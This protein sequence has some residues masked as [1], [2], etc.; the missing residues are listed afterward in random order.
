MTRA[1]NKA[2]RL[3]QI[4]Q[5]LLAH[6]DGLTQAELARRL[7]VDRSVIHRNLIDFQRLY[8]T[9][10]HE[11]GR[12]S[13]DRSAYLVRVAFTLHEALAVHLAARLLATRMDRKNRHAASALR[14]LG[15]ALRRAADQI[16]RHV[17]QSADMMDDEAQRED[18]V[19]LDV[20]EKLTE[21]WARQRK[22]RIWHQSEAGERVAEYLLS[23]YFIE[24]YAVGQTTH[25]F[26]PAQLATETGWTR[27]R[28]LTF[29]IERIRRAELTREPYSTPAD[30]DP[31]EFLAD[32]WGIWRTEDDPVEVALK[33]SA[34]VARRVHETRWH[35]SEQKITQ[36]DGSVIWR[37]SI[38][39]PKEMIPWIRGWGADCEVLDPP[40]L[41]QA[42][43]RE[44]ERMARMYGITLTQPTT[45]YFAHRREGE[46]REE[47]Q[48]LIEHLRNTAELAREFGREAQVGDL[49]Y[50][51]GLVH[52]LGKYSHQFQRR[53]EGGARVDHSTA[54]AKEL[55]GLL[56]GKPQEPIARL[57]AYPIL[58][59]HAGLPDF[60]NETDL[61]SGT[62]CARF[63]NTLP[64]YSAYK[65]E[66]DLSDLPFPQRFHV[67]PQP[68]RSGFSISF[69]TR[70]VFSAL[71]DAD[72]QETE[73]YVKG[74]PVRARNT[75]DMTAL[76]D[77]LDSWM[78]RFDHPTSEINRKRNETLMTCIQKGKTESP[79][80]F[81]LTVPTGGGKTLA[82]MAF[83]LHH[84]ARHGLRRIIYVIPFTSIIE[85]NAGIFK[86]IFG[87]ENVLEH[88]SNF[89]W[90]KLGQS[91][92][93][94]RT[95]SVF[96][97][98]KLAA[99]NWDIPIVVTT[100]VQ[101]FESLF[102]NRSSRC[103]KLHNIARSVVIFDEAQMLP[104]EYMQ[105]A[106]AAV[107]ELVVNYGVS[108][109]FCTA[110]QPRIERFLPPGTS[111]RELIAEPQALFDFYKRVDVKHLGELSDEELLA[112]LNCHDQVLC[113]VNTR[114]HASGLFAGLQ[115]EGN[116]HLS[117]LMCPAHRRIKL[118]EIRSRLANGQPCRVVSTTVME[119][120]IDVDFPVGYRALSGLDSI[121]QAA[122][123]VNREMKRRLGELF[124][125][126]P[127][128][129]FVKRTPSFLKQSAEVARMTLRDYPHAPIS[130]PAV[131]DFFDRLYDLHDPAISFDIKRIMKCFDSEEGKFSFETAAQDFQII[132]TP[133]VTIIIPFN[134]E[135][136][137]LIDELK[138]TPYPSSTLRKLQP[139]TVSIFE[140]EFEKL[141]SKGVVLTLED[142]YHVLNP[143]CFGEYYDCERGLLVPE[144]AGADGL[145]F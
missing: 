71:V 35:R 108:A 119:A 37:A 142:A 86:Q 137:K 82:S 91:Q 132:E 115:G 78:R 128:S 134:E 73:A 95:I 75:V 141:S 84:A 100:N 63:K 56:K 98:L 117:T 124:V 14:K 110:T 105:P 24:P 116:F 62:V 53:L 31:R 48:P 126:E 120:G 77:K 2:A 133:T 99:E 140:S 107:W 29:K 79:G 46:P 10:V 64:D 19:Y 135:A 127:Q 143:D 8:P 39:E 125:F 85:Q 94:D 87:E 43:K 65:T 12:I 102:S 121:N 49:A 123:R 129:E 106:L 9:L 61:E 28:V 138:Y 57:L 80:F 74:R 30:F 50:I 5:L 93:E 104:R 34:K 36:P 27:E 130:V 76:R 44:S 69:L 17:L 67:R 111:V 131:S 81:S 136:L 42:L 55:H 22:A 112:R 25:V 58:G 32:A 88:H 47:W 144:T 6:P 18:P 51:A 118:N 109:V 68:D 41:R 83:A 4:E 23:P 139:Y 1:E 26:G 7:D 60:G 20:L 113:I 33:F 3:L 13:L 103:R 66:L 101:F 89:D 16:S 40:T 92:A 11:D 72:F 15:D 59:H 52:D 97:K 122:G 45:A 70:M 114:R 145:L 90:E 96:T 38:A 54:G 21:A